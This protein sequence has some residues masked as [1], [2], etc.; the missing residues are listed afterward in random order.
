MVRWCCVSRSSEL[1][2]PLLLSFPSAE[3][4][5]PA[6]CG[7]AVATLACLAVRQFQMHF[8]PTSE[9]AVRRRLRIIQP[10]T[11]DLSC[12]CCTLPHCPASH[13]AESCRRCITSS[14]GVAWGPLS[15]C[16]RAGPPL[17]PLLSLSSPL[18]S[19]SSPSPRAGV[20]CRWTI[21]S[22]GCVDVRPSRRARS[23]ASARRPWRSSW[24]R[25]TY[26]EWRPPSPS[27]PTT[28]QHHSAHS[29][30][31]SPPQ[32]SA[33]PLLPSDLLHVCAVRCGRSA[34]T[35]TVSST[36]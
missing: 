24:K 20:R 31:A 33:L 35:S 7:A 23:R 13:S 26:R 36:T 16:S 4:Q 11:S 21:R 3:C 22:S 8:V 1:C 18:P 12:I 29:P 30:A 14:S 9:L 28:P 2:G 5:W 19:T 27:D 17:L 25:V 6:A 10:Q 32:T 34:A 15:C